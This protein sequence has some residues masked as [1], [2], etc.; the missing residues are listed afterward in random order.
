MKPRR[1][2]E[3]VEL[4]KLEPRERTS[5]P[6]ATRPGGAHV[7]VTA[8]D[9]GEGPD[10]PADTPEGEPVLRRGAVPRDERRREERQRSERDEVIER[11]P[12]ASR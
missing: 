7:A 3:A 4:G 10:V 9:D 11:E 12:N 5:G 1:D 8:I 2:R 6:T